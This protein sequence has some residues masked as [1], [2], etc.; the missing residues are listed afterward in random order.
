MPSEELE[1]GKSRR[2]RSR[3]RMEGAGMLLRWSGELC[4]QEI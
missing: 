4:R 3:K 1:E 2:S